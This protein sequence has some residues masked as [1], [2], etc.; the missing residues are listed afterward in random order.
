MAQA[1]ASPI[2]VITGVPGAGKSTVAR[3]LVLRYG[4]GVHIPVDDVRERVVSGLAT[5]VP[6][7]TAETGRQFALAYRATGKMARVYAEAGFAVALD[8]VFTPVDIAANLLPELMGLPL[9]KIYLAP[10]VAIALDR[11]AQR[12][13]KDFDPTFLIDT[14]RGMD[15]WLAEQ[16]DA[17]PGWLRVDNSAL[18]VDETVDAILAGIARENG[19]M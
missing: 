12:D 2:F 3:A 1:Q 5:P 13:N 8:H 10:G 17:D 19:P 9:I 15:G 7:W 6:T 4:F 16:I 18:S 11:S 14:I